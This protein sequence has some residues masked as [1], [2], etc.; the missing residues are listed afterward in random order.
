MFDPTCREPVSQYN[1]CTAVYIER[2]SVCVCAD[3]NMLS[4]MAAH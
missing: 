3:E 1:T 2:E 4:S